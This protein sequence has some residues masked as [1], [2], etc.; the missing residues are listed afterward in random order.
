MSLINLYLSLFVLDFFQMHLIIYCRRMRWKM[1]HQMIHMKKVIY[2]PRNSNNDSLFYFQTI[3]STFTNSKHYF[4]FEQFDFSVI[5]C[6]F[7]SFRC[8]IKYWE[9]VIMLFCLQYDSCQYTLYFAP[10][11]SF[12]L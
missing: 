11:L 3:Q 9:R 6:I 4:G 10:I 12:R 1:I 8:A 2:L 7:Q 5:Y